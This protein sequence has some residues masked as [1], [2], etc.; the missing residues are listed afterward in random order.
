MDITSPCRFNALADILSY[1][2]HYLQKNSNAVLLPLLSN[3]MSLLTSTIFLTK[4]GVLGLPV[5]WPVKP[6]WYG[7]VTIYFNGLLFHLY[8]SIQPP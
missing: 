4:T 7:S 2:H 6:M 8:L 5:G 1:F 3:Q